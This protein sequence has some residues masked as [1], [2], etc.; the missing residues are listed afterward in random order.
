MTNRN[1][2]HQ[3]ILRTGHTNRRPNDRGCPGVGQRVRVV[4]GR[5]VCPWCNGEFKVRKDGTVKAHARP[6]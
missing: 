2:G 3:A 6:A 4:N 1:S 5:A